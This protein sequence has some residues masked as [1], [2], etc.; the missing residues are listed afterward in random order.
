MKD[1]LS[2]DNRTQTAKHDYCTQPVNLA[3]LPA[4]TVPVKL[5]LRSLPLSIQIIGRPGRDDEVLALAK[6]IEDMVQFPRLHLN[7]E[8]Y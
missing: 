3:G 2:S 6:F 5:S 4:A 8:L 7:E 1:F